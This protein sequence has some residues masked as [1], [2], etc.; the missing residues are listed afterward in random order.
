MLPLISS[1]ERED[2]VISADPAVKLNKADRE[3]VRALVK[4]DCDLNGTPPT[5]FTVRPLKSR[6]MIRVINASSLSATE[7]LV[8]AAEIGITSINHG[9]AVVSK[10]DEI[11]KM[12]DEQPHS[13]ILAVGAWLINQSSLPEDPEEPN[14]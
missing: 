13:A 10:V 1:S 5:I 9:G 11:D 2:L 14:E 3:P 4:K 6:E 12:I 8:R 7:G